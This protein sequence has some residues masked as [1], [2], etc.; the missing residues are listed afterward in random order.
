MAS[1]STDESVVL[2]KWTNRGTASCPKCGHKYMTARKPKLCEGCH[3]EIG[4]SYVPKPKL[5]IPDCVIVY[6][7]GDTSLYS[8]N[9]STRDDRCLVL[10]Q[11]TNCLCY[12]ETCKQQRAIH[13]S[14][15]GRPFSCKHSE[16]IDSKPQEP[17]E[18]YFL[19]D[20]SI[21]TYPA[22][23]GTQ[24]TIF[25]LMKKLSAS[26]AVAMKVSDKNFVVYGKAS[27]S[28]PICYTHVQFNKGNY[29]CSSKDCK[30]HGGNTKQLKSKR[31][32]LHVHVLLCV[33]RE[34]VRP[35]AVPTPTSPEEIAEPRT[36]SVCR[37][38]TVDLMAR[39]S[40][41]YPVPNKFII[42]CRNIDAWSTAGI[43]DKS[44]PSSFIPPQES[45]EM[46]GTQLS[47]P[48]MKPG[49]DGKAFLMTHQ[50]MFH[51]VE[52]LV[53]FCKNPECQAMHRVW[54]LSDGLFNINDKVL[55]ALEILVEWR[56]LFKRGVPVKVFVE[57]TIRSW[58]ATT[59]SNNQTLFL[60]EDVIPSSG[61][62][63]YLVELLY[64][65]FYCFEAITERSLDD[66]ICGVCGVAGEVYCGD[67]NEKN[68][69]DLSCV[70]F[71]NSSSN[72]ECEPVSLEDFLM[73]I[74]KYWVEKTTYTKTELDDGKVDAATVPPIIAPSARAEKVYNTEMQKRSVF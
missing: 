46:C 22:D 5:N 74:K 7:E 44:W 49:S 10:M 34:H 32:C 66:V 25:S 28:T 17:F 18:K 60:F 4:G 19:S 53:K 1:G 16:K 21:R 55:L 57:S 13:L 52:V 6:K 8:V 62:Q 43:E 61:Q 3:F 59:C 35:T 33:L 54:P 69:C 29:I 70:N 47:L 2:P 42:K 9:S 24:E 23:N 48:K 68:C 58:C 31:I 27:T 36:S 65:G 51:V 63:R 64:N 30:S 56:E 20:E 12:H 40:L 72:N 50:H 14:S 15:S 41:P 45:C 38:R 71:N 67:G 37:Q 11:G 39:C 26:Q 73:R